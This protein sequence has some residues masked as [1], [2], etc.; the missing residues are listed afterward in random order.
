[1]EGNNEIGTLNNYSLKREVDSPFDNRLVLWNS[2]F[3]WTDKLTDSVCIPYRALTEKNIKTSYFTIKESA[4]NGIEHC[5][6]R[7]FSFYMKQMRRSR[8]AG[9]TTA[10]IWR[11]FWG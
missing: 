10:G 9:S 4:G 5:F 11:Q 7:H 3:E 1:M 2:D 8:N 6:Y